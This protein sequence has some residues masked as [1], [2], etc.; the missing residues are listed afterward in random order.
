[1]QQLAKWLVVVLAGFLG[2]CAAPTFRNVVYDNISPTARVLDPFSNVNYRANDYRYPP[3]SV[4]TAP[5]SQPANP[6]TRSAGL[7][8][9]RTGQFD[10]QCFQKI[11]TIKKAGQVNPTIA[12]VSIS[13]DMRI[14]IGLPFGNRAAMDAFRQQPGMQ[15]IPD[16]VLAYVRQV[17]YRIKHIRVYEPNTKQLQD[18]V[19]SLSATCGSFATPL[20][21]LVIRKVYVGDITN[22]V[23]WDEGYNV[24][25]AALWKNRVQRSLRASL[26]GTGVIFAVEVDPLPLYQF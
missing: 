15:D 11:F 22:Y 21:S 23:R 8:S 12:D 6:F 25:G 16:N 4:V 1:M 13:N 20:R 19:K 26:S 18:A 2:G 14:L 7:I 17:D 5:L 9:G 10:V 3:G 24:A